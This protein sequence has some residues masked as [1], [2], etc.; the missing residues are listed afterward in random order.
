MAFALK[1]NIQELQDNGRSQ[2][3]TIPWRQGCNCAGRWLPDRPALKGIS[4]PVR[5]ST[6]KIAVCHFVPETAVKIYT[7]HLLKYFVLN[8]IWH[9]I[10]A[11]HQPCL[12]KNWL[13]TTFNLFIIN[14]L[15]NSF[16]SKLCVLVPED[17]PAAEKYI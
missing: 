3:H 17:W 9:W 14:I 1:S 15:G 8:F 12:K 7:W 13:W 16:E 5:T 6:K 11:S 2:D 4:G 10:W